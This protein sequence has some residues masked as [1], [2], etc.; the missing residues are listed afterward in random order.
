MYVVTKVNPP[1]NAPRKPLI[2]PEIK[3]III[4]DK[5]RVT[6]ILDLIFKV[7]R[8]IFVYVS[9]H[10]SH[11]YGLH[12]VKDCGMKALNANIRKIF[13]MSHIETR[14]AERANITCGKALGNFFFSFFGS[15][16]NL[17]HSKLK[18]SFLLSLL[19]VFAQLVLLS[20]ILLLFLLIALHFYIMCGFD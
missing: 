19:E 15:F 12:E 7:K 16:V 18:L 14:M 4:L 3:A 6:L 2:T 9:R 1:A 20:R 5:I 11:L 13:G 10:P 17:T 8:Y